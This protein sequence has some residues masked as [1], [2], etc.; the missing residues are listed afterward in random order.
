[1]MVEAQDQEVTELWANKIADA[2][3]S[4]S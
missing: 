3:K 4:V 1:V 2:V